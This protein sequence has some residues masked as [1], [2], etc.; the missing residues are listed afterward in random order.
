MHL[1]L[2][3]DFQKGLSINLEPEDNGIIPFLS[4]TAHLVPYR[5]CGRPFMS[6]N[7]SVGKLSESD[8]SQARSFSLLVGGMRRSSKASTTQSGGRVR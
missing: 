8:Y 2:K 6:V 1:G 5:Y 3:V 4:P 7:L